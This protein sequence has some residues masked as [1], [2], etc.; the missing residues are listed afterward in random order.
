MSP[1]GVIIV[2]KAESAQCFCTQSFISVAHS[3]GLL[4]V[5]CMHTKGGL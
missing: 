4:L 1:S 2:T 5:E 3:V